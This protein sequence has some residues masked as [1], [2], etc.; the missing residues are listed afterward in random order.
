MGFQLVPKLVTLSDFERHTGYVVCV[1]LP[2][3]LAF[4]TY[5]VRVVEDTRIHSESEML[6]EESSLQWYIIYGDIRM[7]SP[8]ARALK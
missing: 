3:S 5:Y 2:N 4:G 8:P 7:V 1:I 6:F